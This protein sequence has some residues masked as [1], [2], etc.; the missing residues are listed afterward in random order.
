VRTLLFLPANL[1]PGHARQV[2]NVD[3]AEL[4]AALA[5]DGAASVR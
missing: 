2:V 1:R 5:A 4:A 3:P